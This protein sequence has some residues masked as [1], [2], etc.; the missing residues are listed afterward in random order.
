MIKFKSSILTLAMA[1]GALATVSTGC[2]NDFLDVDSKTQQNTANYYRT[3][4]DAWRALMGCYDGWKETSTNKDAGTGFYLVSTIMSDETYGASGNGDGRGPQAIDRFDQAQSP[5]DQD[6]LVNIWKL[7]YAAV[8]RCNELITREGQIQWVAGSGNHGLYI[9]EARALRAMLYFDMVRLWGNIPLFLEPSKENREQA[10]PE[11]V[12]AAIIDDLKYAKD[13]IPASANTLPDEAGRITR[14]AAEAMLARVYLFYTGY[15]GKEPEGLT[16]AEALAGLE[17]VISSHRFSLVPEYK[18]LWPAASLVPIPDN[19][20]WNTE[21]S[22]YAG[23]GNPE[24]L[25]AMKFTPTSTWSGPFDGNRWAVMIGMRDIFAA[26][27]GQGWGFATVCPSYLAKFDAD[28]PRVSASVTDMETEVRPVVGDD[29]YTRSKNDW[30][31][32][33]G[34]VL[35]KYCPLRYGNGSTGTNPSGTGDMQLDNVQQYVI[36]RYADVLMMAAELGSTNAQTYFDRVRA[37]SGRGPLTAN[38]ENIMAER[39]REFAFEG[40]RYWDLLRQ[41]VDVMANAV[42]ASGGQVLN[43][44][45]PGTVTYDVAKIKATQGLCQIPH[46]QVTLSN[47]VLKQN[48]GWN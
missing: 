34:Y 22:T 40:I 26:P 31:E 32:F 37:R 11:D 47:G 10:R 20:G 16:K 13:N 6:L 15:Y 18:N 35:K 29:A 27:M 43:G 45:V 28:D 3:E 1:F 30:R 12:Y 33:T 5:A 42:A 19:T 9:G 14:Y 46:E 23:D 17:D 25:L 44:S 24:I 39:A 21:K 7:Y 2:T 8:Y 36:M 48:H 4:D 38:K 41:G